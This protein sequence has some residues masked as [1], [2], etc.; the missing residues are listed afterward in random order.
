MQ[1]FVCDGTA[2]E[3]HDRVTG[4]FRSVDC[5]NCD[6]YDISNSMADTGIF[7][8]LAPE[9]RRQALDDAKRAAQPGKRPMIKDI[10]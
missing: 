6:E 1:C 5:P 8:K 10:L 9:R 3:R 2:E 4:D 7:A